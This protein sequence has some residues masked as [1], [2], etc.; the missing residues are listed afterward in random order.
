MQP[1]PEL[2]TLGL[3]FVSVTIVQ[4]GRLSEDMVCCQA[5]RDLGSCGVKTRLFRLRKGLIANVLSHFVGICCKAGICDKLT[6]LINKMHR[7][8]LKFGC[9]LQP[10]VKTSFLTV[11]WTLS[12]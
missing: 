3:S 4:W 5:L 7:R 11:K 9:A 2:K 12:A 6:F 10:Q 8:F 1:T